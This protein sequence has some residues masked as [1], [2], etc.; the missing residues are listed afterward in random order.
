MADTPTPPAAPAAAPEAGSAGLESLARALR[1]S[2]TLLIVAMFV[3]VFIFLKR[4]VFEVQN[5]EQG[6][7]L[8]FG[9]LR[10]SGMDTVL[11]PGAHFTLPEPI[12]EKIAVP[13]GREQ[14]VRSADWFMAKTVEGLV[15]ATLAPGANGYTLTGDMNIIHSRWVLRYTISNPERYAF[16]VYDPAA[17]GDSALGDERGRNP[18]M[19]HLLACLLRNAVTQ[20]AGSMPVDGAWRNRD[21]Q[22][23]TRVEALLREKTRALDLGIEVRSVALEGGNAQPPAQVDGAFTAVTRAEDERGR[24]RAEAQNVATR[25]RNTAAIEASRIVADATTYRQNVTQTVAAEAENFDKLLH[26]YRKNPGIISQ[27]LYEDT[28]RRIL[29]ATPRKYVIQDHPGQQLRINLEPPK[30]AAADGQPQP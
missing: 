11:E 2:F 21:G 23:T 28:I 18:A 26:E 6:L 19:E 22:F 3:G 30:K 9:A 10:G 16:R 1:V 4:S 24:A 12:D 29:A 27:T 14:E 13:V 20:A 7:V 17:A 25:T 8:R 5:Q 15:P